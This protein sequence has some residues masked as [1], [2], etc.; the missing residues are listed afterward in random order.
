MGATLGIPV[1]ERQSVRCGELCTVL[2]ASPSN[3]GVCRQ[4]EG[5][6]PGLGHF[7][8]SVSFLWSP[9]TPSPTHDPSPEVLSHMKSGI[10]CSFWA[11]ALGITYC[12]V[13]KRTQNAAK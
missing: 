12:C 11:R 3:A 4:T 13:A 8:V 9:S 5:T 6:Q 7:W 2:H 10:D 1:H